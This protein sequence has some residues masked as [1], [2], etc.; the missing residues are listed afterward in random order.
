MGKVVFVNDFFIDEYVGGA[1][2]TSESLIN[3]STSVVNK[4]KSSEITLETIEKFKDHVWLFGNF[5]QMHL[6]LIM[7]I[8]KSKIEYHII[9]YDFKF[10]ELRSPEKH[11]LLGDTCS[12]EKEESGK[13]ISVFFANSK[14][15]WYMSQKQKAVYEG[16][17]G[18]LKQRESH[19]LSSI[20]SEETLDKLQELKSERNNKWMILNSQSWI[21]GTQET[22][23][24]AVKNNLDYDL[25][26]NVS[27]EK[28]MEM[29]SKSKGFIFLPKGG[30]TCPRVVIEAKLLGCELILN[31]NV[32]HKDEDWFNLEREGI[33]KYLKSRPNFFW[34]TIEKECT[35]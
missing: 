25:V 19:V 32:L 11:I 13:L 35:Q 12:C 28:M 17:F 18:F 29:F 24:Y 15:I 6:P 33:I 16:R 8:I 21:K 4:I 27:Y 10:C 9:E 7:Q 22:I 23:E 26:G 31:D 2:L 30:D 5:C 20:F 3:S 34:N 1:E 14:M